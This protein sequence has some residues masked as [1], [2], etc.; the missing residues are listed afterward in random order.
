[1]RLYFI[2]ALTGSKC[3]TYPPSSVHLNAHA[4][5]NRQQTMRGSR[6]FFFRGGPAFL[7]F[8]SWLRERGS[9]YHYKRAIIDPPAKRHIMAF[10]WRAD[11]GPTSI[12]ASF[13][14]GSGPVML[15][16]PTFL[17]FFSGEGAGP[18]SPL[19]IRP[20]KRLHVIHASTGPI[21]M[22]PLS[23]V[24]SAFEC[25]CYYKPAANA[26][27]AYPLTPY[28]ESVT[29]QRVSVQSNNHGANIMVK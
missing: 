3:H 5:I 11:D 28:N 21:Q 17:C 25:T 18:L 7:R 13:F 4:T 12:M 9:K 15:K 23:S 6:F 22:S 27:P 2:Q 29:A 1:M 16:N 24:V 20:Y 26:V 10:R 19:W 8:I 14:R